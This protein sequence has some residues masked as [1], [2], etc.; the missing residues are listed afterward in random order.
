M[1]FFGLR[2][3]PTP[4]RPIFQSSS[5][6][7]KP[8]YSQIVK[9]LW[10]FM[11]ASGVTFYLISKAQDSGVRCESFVLKDFPSCL[12]FTQ[13]FNGATTRETLM[14]L[15]SPR[16]HYIR[17]NLAPRSTRSTRHPIESQL[18]LI[19]G[20]ESNVV[21]RITKANANLCPSTIAH[22]WNSPIRDFGR[23]SRGL[24]VVS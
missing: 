20:S 10:P 24:E 19:I 13:P 3:W 12:K 14:L 6:C 8:H 17:R 18:I 1:A 21:A 22:A 5:V 15:S 23:T 9:P 11:L 4:V 16:R 7:G 2:K